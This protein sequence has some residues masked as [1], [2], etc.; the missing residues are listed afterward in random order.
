LFVNLQ[1]VDYGATAK[2]KLMESH[3]NLLN[4]SRPLTGMAI[5]SGGGTSF[6][7]QPKVAATDNHRRLNFSGVRTEL[8]NASES[9]GV[10]R[11]TSGLALASGMISLASGKSG[12]SED[13]SVSRSECI[14][15]ELSMANT[16]SG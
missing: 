9:S 14:S 8:G 3:F 7:L 10:Q 4:F 6:H 13:V 15:E 11:R 16:S 1:F 12:T 5:A 2:V